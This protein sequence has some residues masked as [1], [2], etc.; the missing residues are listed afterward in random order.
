MEVIESERG[1]KESAM[2]QRLHQESR[3]QESGMADDNSDHPD[4]SGM[5]R[6]FFDVYVAM[7]HRCQ[8]ANASEVLK[9]LL[10]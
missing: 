4:V 9:N 3:K 5:C 10:G 7:T 8:L 1:G 6:I 2:L